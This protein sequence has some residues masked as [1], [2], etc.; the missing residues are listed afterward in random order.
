MSWLISLLVAG[1]VFSSGSNLTDLNDNYSTV[2]SSGNAAPVVLDETERFEKTYSF[3]KNGRVEISNINGSINI[4]SWDRN[5]I[6]FEYVK[7]AS[8]KER[9]AD[10]TVNIDAQSNH[11]KVS[12]DYKKHKNK[13]K[14][15]KN[16]CKLSVDF[17]LT[18]PKTARLDAVESVNGSVVVSN[19][20]NF[21]EITAVNGTVKATNLRGTA[22][23]S[24]VNGTVYADFDRLDSSSTISLE[25]VNGSVKL[26]IPSDSNATLKAETTNGSIKNDF[27]LPVRKGKYVG[28]DLH[29]KIGNGEVKINLSSVNGGLSISRKQD[30]KNLSPSTNLLK[31]K[32]TDDEDDEFEVRVE[33]STSVGTSRKTRNDAK[34]AHRAAV[35][36]A[37]R[38]VRKA[39]REGGISAAEVDKIAKE[40]LVQAEKALKELG[41]EKIRI[42][43]KVLEK[44]ESKMLEK[45]LRETKNPRMEM[46][47]NTSDAFFSRNAP[48]VEEKTETFKV[49]GIPDVGIEALNCAV[50][51]RGWS[52][53]K[54][55]YTVSRV[56]R[57]PS[58]RPVL[59]QTETKDGIRI[60]VRAANSPGG[61]MK[62]DDIR[63]EVYV[64]KKS[65][66]EIHTHRELRVE[67][68][69]GQIKLDTD[70][71]SVN[72]RDSSG[73]LHLTTAN[74]YKRN[75]VRIVGFEGEV[76][77]NVVNSDTYLEGE[78]GKISAKGKG[79]NFYLTLPED[80]DAMI[81]TNS[82]GVRGKIKSGSTFRV[83][84]IE[85]TKED[86]GMWRLG[87]GDANYVFDLYK[88]YTYIRS[89]DSIRSI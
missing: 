29:G 20:T 50:I 86:A 41:V 78:F 53:D 71:S 35:R 63:L 12:T 2:R 62:S 84:G 4:D 85:V 58:H 47:K 48:F 87:D 89:R 54:V 72:V 23:L 61:L 52:K 80:A 15:G 22:D 14:W 7:V 82:F 37:N 83:G 8:T 60:K 49:E 38:E 44:I 17:K 42:D 10:L 16:C 45:A 21:S 81:E 30:G 66:L 59:I 5:E 36:Q 51:V 1:A 6:K 3:D 67:G 69:S 24:T 31:L 56:K 9:L 64:P 27:R 26:F 55:K 18:V 28:R 32:S 39:I 70:D 73:S 74:K 25:T 57:S 76:I 19:M 75:R 40:A 33:T 77:A 79:S 43:A 46:L 88:G 65:N 68:V 11:F 13:K 34:R